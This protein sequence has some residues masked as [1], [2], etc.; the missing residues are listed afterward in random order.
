MEFSSA[1]YNGIF[2]VKIMLTV[3]FMPLLIIKNKR[4]LEPWPVLSFEMIKNSNLPFRK[5]NVWLFQ[6]GEA[7][8]LEFVSQ[9]LTVNLSFY[10]EVLKRSCELGV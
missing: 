1:N 10:L 7:L 6:A 2:K 3:K 8:Y 5:Q 4:H 9:T